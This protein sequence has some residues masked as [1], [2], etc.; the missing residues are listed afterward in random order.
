M[1]WQPQ[2]CPFCHKHYANKK[3]LRNHLYSYIGIWRFPADGIHDVLKIDRILHAGRKDLAYKCP[4]CSLILTPKAAFVDHVF[5]RKHY[6]IYGNSHSQGIKRRSGAW[7]LQRRHQGLPTKR[8]LSIFPF[9]L[10]SV[11][12]MFRILLSG[13]SRFA[14]FCSRKYN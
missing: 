11:T 5:Y 10:W 6:G 4:S 1:P 12:T 8:G 13:H 9:T 14:N 3:G 7:P 2:V